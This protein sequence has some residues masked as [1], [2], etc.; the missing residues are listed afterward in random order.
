MAFGALAAAFGASISGQMIGGLEKL[1][2]KA[3]EAAQRTANI[4]AI[5]TLNLKPVAHMGKAF[6]K[7]ASQTELTS[8]ELKTMHKSASM[9]VNMMKKSNPMYKDAV[10]NERKTY[11]CYSSI[12]YG[13]K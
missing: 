6:N 7:L 2:E 10:K 3:T 12:Y 11:S 13:C 8:D 1:G 5:R 9:T 4:G